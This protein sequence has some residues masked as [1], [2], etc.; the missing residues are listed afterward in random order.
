MTGVLGEPT[1][2][3]SKFPT[4]ARLDPGR[5]GVLSGESRS[6][7]LW[8]SDADPAVAAAAWLSGTSAQDRE[9]IGAMVVWTLICAVNPF[10][11][12]SGS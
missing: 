3:C 8:C 12:E 10:N 1:A 7:T 11:G 2:V 6:V 4:F 5:A 9:R